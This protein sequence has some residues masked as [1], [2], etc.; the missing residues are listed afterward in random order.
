M[1]VL[2][3][4]LLSQETIYLW[5]ELDS[6][7]QEVVA[8]AFRRGYKRRTVRHVMRTFHA[9]NPKV[10]IANDNSYSRLGSEHETMEVLLKKR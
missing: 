2:K 8:D 1:E 7:Q 10:I 6:S 9:V 4:Q 5:S 3:N